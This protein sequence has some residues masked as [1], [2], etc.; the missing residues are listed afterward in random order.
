ML[1]RSV[2]TQD[3][4]KENAELLKTN[5]EIKTLQDKI[6]QLEKASKETT[7]NTK[8]SA[9]LPDDSKKWQAMDEENQAMRVRIE[10]ALANLKGENVP[11]N[12]E[13]ATI[14]PKF[15]FWYWMT[16]LFVMVIGAGAGIFFYDYYN[17]KRHGGFRL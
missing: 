8:E 16:I 11:S 6:A 13:L 2:R 1:F 7:A 12:A 14:R 3:T 15:P 10:T 9:S 4:A 17:R 5:A